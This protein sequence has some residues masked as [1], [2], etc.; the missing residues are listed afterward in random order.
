[1]ELERCECGCM[2]V[3]K[4]I[5]TLKSNMVGHKKSNYHKRQIELIKLKEKETSPTEN[6][7]LQQHDHSNTTR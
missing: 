2:I 7:Q 3:G 1:M 5:N 6:L 4:D